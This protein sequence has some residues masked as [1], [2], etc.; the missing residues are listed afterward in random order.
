M[1]WGVHELFG[2]GQV[3]DG[4]LVLAGVERRAPVVGCVASSRSL[5]VSLREYTVGCDEYTDTRHQAGNSSHAVSRR[6]VGQGRQSCHGKLRSVLDSSI[7]ALT[8]D[9][10]RHRRTLVRSAALRCVWSNRCRVILTE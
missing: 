8:G 5:Q 6:I 7:S 10:L 1:R 9:A 4:L 3:V 2:A